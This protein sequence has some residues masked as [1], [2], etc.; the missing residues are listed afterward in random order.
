MIWC[1][2]SRGNWGQTP[3]AS[4]AGN[5]GEII[6]RLLMNGAVTDEE[7]LTHVDISLG[8]VAGI[9]YSDGGG[10]ELGFSATD[11][12]DMTRNPFVWGAQ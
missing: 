2:L 10:C 12:S 1:G 9:V 3:V 4:G 7:R 5:M 11:V 8:R 6:E